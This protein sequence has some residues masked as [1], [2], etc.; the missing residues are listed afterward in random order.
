MRNNFFL[1]I[2]ITIISALIITSCSNENNTMD[3]NLTVGGLYI[4][5][6]KEGSYGVTKILAI[7]GSTVHIRMYD[8]KFEKAPADLNTADLKFIIGHM[9]VAKKGFLL[10]SPKLLKVE[11][12]SEEELEGYK[13]Y[14]EAMKNQ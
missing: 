6:S 4:T 8:D 10:D 7:D 1:L 5:Q 12:V 11:K 3:N 13:Y 14:L 2:I 9:P